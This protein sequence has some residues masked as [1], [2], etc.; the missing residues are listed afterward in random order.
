MVALEATGI[1]EG[2]YLRVRLDDTTTGRQLGPAAR[3]EVRYTVLDGVE[4]A[5]NYVTAEDRGR[6]PFFGV[7]DIL[8]AVNR[9]APHSS[10][11]KVKL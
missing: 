5:R 11:H 2:G 1:A 8:S 4:P 7:M 6:P 3:I 10:S 9:R